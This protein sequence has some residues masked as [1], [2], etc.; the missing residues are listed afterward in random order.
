[1]KWPPLRAVFKAFAA[2]SFRTICAM[3][4][5]RPLLD[6]PAPAGTTLPRLALLT[7]GLQRIPTLAALLPDWSLQTRGSPPAD[8]VLA[9]GQKPSA[10]VAEAY[11]QRHGVPLWRAEDGFLRSVGLGHQDPPLSVVLDDL[12]IY[13]DASAPSRL[14]RLIA[15]PLDAA[16]AQRA[17]RLQQAWVQGRVS[18]YNPV[19][20]GLPA[21]LLSHVQDAAAPR[22]VLVVDQTYGDA[23]ITGSGAGPADFERMLAAALAEHP[24]APVWLKVH[25]DVVAGLKRGHFQDW[26]QENPASAIRVT[27]IA[28]DVHPPALLEACGAVYV[29]SSQMGFEALLWGRPVRCFGMPF[30]AGWGLTA[31][32]MPPP[33]RRQAARPTLA[34]LVH[35]ALIDYPRYLDPETGQRCEVETLLAYLALQRQTRGRWPQAVTV[36]GFSRW[37]RPI[38]RDF[39]Q[40]A[41][42]QFSRAV[43]AGVPAASGPLA[44]W[45]RRP[46]PAGV[47]VLRLEDGFIRSVG[48][49]ADLVRPL[50]WVVDEVGIYFDAT[51][52]SRLEQCLAQHAFD[53]PLRARAAA[54]RTAIVAAGLTKYNVGAGTW[55]RPPGARRVVLVPGQVEADASIRWGSAGITT[56]AGLLA[57][58]RR[59]EPEA[60]IVYKP[61]P[62]VLAGLRGGA[63]VP[64]VEAEA[65]AG[66]AGVRLFDECVTDVPMQALLAQVDAV[67]TLTSLTGFEALMRG[68]AVTTWGVPFYAGWGLTTDRAPAD[69]PAWARRGRRLDLDDLVA[70][71]LILYPTYVSRRSGAYTTPERALCELQAWRQQV[72]TRRDRWQRA[73]LRLRRSVLGW[74]A[75]RRDAR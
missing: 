25:P 31:D 15:Q 43:S 34:A 45:G 17:T 20:E 2:Q 7:R 71:T 57:A 64:E 63:V 42:L 50:S 37:K 21:R 30:Y 4:T 44:V 56:N 47:P 11:A 61:H 28:E 13:Y 16:Q 49:G 32:E 51:R 66:S 58:A 27:L 75:G 67:H 52:P 14:E 5:T 36:I 46:A 73:W 59:A 72:P 10:R 38:A 39:L 22:P 24:D 29:V 48:L 1:L 60:W 18:K 70:A 19:R 53:A 35:A 54:L 12:G 6:V 9:W 65:A 40:G 69:H 8:A 33:T 26:L 68:V 23:S 3:L 41:A 62:D 55:Q 74:M